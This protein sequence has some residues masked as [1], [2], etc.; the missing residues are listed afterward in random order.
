[1]N[2]LKYVLI[3]ERDTMKHTHMIYKNNLIGKSLVIKCSKSVIGVYKLMTM[4]SSFNTLTQFSLCG[5]I[6]VKPSNNTIT[7][8]Q[9]R[10]SWWRALRKNSIEVGCYD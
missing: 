4:R 8:N 7:T 6:C 9:S 2:L 10:H 1:M 3:F 5:K